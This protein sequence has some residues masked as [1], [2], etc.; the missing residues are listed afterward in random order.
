MEIQKVILKV[1]LI[2]IYSTRIFTVK[3]GG[4]GGKWDEFQVK[5]NFSDT[6]LDNRNK[7]SG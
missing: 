7:Y 1:P 5:E 4:G 3:N 6:L 2:N